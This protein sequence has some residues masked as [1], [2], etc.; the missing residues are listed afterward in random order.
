MTE[1][2]H[3]CPHCSAPILAAYAVKAVGDW[4]IEILAIPFGDVDSDGQYFDADTD[5]M[6]GTLLHRRSSTNTV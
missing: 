5:I 3:N 2:N 4:E 6:E 1:E